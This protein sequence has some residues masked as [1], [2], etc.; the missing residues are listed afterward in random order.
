[1]IEVHARPELS[2]SDR[3]QALTLSAFEQLMRSAAPFAAAAG[4]RMPA[5]NA[6]PATQTAHATAPMRAIEVTP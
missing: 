2:R 5:A 1:M 4:R 6:A 3:E